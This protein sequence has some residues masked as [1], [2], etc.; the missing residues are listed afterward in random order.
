MI[1]FITHIK[2]ANYAM[3]KDYD[4]SYQMQLNILNIN[5]FFLF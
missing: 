4:F 5:V 3:K 1:K 2:S